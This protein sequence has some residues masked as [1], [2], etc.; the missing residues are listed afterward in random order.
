MSTNPFE[1][2][3]DS[4]AL[5]NE[6]EE[7]KSEASSKPAAPA[8]PFHGIIGQCFEPHLHIYVES[9]DR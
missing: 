6:D 8:H 3:A 4:S 5:N 9:L 7:V 2:D 1:N